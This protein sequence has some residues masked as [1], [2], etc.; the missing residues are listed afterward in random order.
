MLLSEKIDRFDAFSS[1]IL[2]LIIKKLNYFGIQSV[3][4]L[5]M[6]NGNFLFFFLYSCCSLSWI[7]QGVFLIFSIFGLEF[8]NSKNYVYV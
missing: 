6:I 2:N 1:F 5:L 3:E 7:N 8:S 4:L